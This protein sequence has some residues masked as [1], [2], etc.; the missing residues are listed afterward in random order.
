MTISESGLVVK[1]YDGLAWWLSW[2]APTDWREDHHIDGTFRACLSVRLH[3]QLPDQGDVYHATLSQYSAGLSYAMRNSSGAADSKD[4]EPFF[5]NW[6]HYESGDT[7]ELFDVFTLEDG[8]LKW[9]SSYR[10]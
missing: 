6:G 3:A 1:Q 2:D 7:E 4:I 8:V 5:L 10:K 9:R